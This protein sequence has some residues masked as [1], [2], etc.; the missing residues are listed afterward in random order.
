M[1]INIAFLSI[2]EYYG[3]SQTLYFVA[4][5]LQGFFPVAGVSVKVLNEFI[6]MD[7]AHLGLRPKQEPTDMYINYNLLERRNISDE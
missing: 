2:Y 5:C 3:S 6:L 1:Q 4:V 7:I